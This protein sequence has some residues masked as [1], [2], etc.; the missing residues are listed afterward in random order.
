MTNTSD[1]G[2]YE[3]LDYA[4]RWLRAALEIVSPPG[5]SQAVEVDMNACRDAIEAARQRGV[6]ATYTHAFVRAAALA[7]ADD[8]ELH[9]LVVG[10]RRWIPGRVDIGLSVAAES[11][12]A[13]VVVIEDVSRKT[14]E[15]IAT[16]VS[17]HTPRVRAEHEQF[18]DGI[19]RWGWFAPFAWLRRTVLK[20]LVRRF[21]FIR[22]T[23]GTFQISCLR[24]VDLF[25][26][27]L[28][29]TTAIMGT[30]QVRERAVV[31]NGEVAVRPTVLIACCA[32]HGVW[33]GLRGA[34]FLNKVKS[35]LEAGHL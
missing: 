23:N 14:L 4:D 8:E 19:R 22:S 24:D 28:F 31:V 3:R 25:V 9:Q 26:P 30:G 35:V 16:E 7:L 13:P 33:D 20:R 1:S 27:F 15:Q 21:S 18:L 32:D 6:Q 12:V 34:R 11:F 10:N 2:R 29:S 5:F 17:E